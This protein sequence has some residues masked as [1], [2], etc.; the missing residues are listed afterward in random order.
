M[1]MKKLFMIAPLTFGVFLINACFTAK[2]V[3][4]TKQTFTYDYKT[5]HTEKPGSAGILV[6]LV[7]PR[8]ANEFVRQFG[9][10]DVFVNWRKFI[11]DDIEELLIDKGYRIKNAYTSFDN[12]TYDEKKDVDVAL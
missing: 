9:D 3:V 12:M 2:Q 11:G 4:A 5:T 1:V 6:T 7:R 8:Y 10:A